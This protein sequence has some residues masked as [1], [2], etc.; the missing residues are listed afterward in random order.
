[1]T[2]VKPWEFCGVGFSRVPSCP[3]ALAKTAKC[4]KLQRA[5]YRARE[6]GF[7]PALFSG[8]A[9]KLRGT[10]TCEQALPI[11][12][13]DFARS[14]ECDIAACSWPFALPGQS[15][16]ACCAALPGQSRLTQLL[17]LQGSVEK[18]E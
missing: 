10:S 7:M 4:R 16:G 3:L 13:V 14:S 15:C 11:I 2:A 17:D 18:E 6:H 5:L 9:I 1:M 12:R 8:R